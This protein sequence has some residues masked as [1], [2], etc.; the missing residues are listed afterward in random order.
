MKVEI[1][2]PNDIELQ[3]YIQFFYILTHSKETKTRYFIFPNT[4]SVVSFSLNVISKRKNNFIE[5][6]QSPNDNFNSELDISFTTPLLVQY[7]G[8]IKEITIVFKTLGLNVF[9]DKTLNTY[10]KEDYGFYPFLDYSDKMQAILK[11]NSKEEAFEE[12]EKYLLSKI[13]SKSY[14]KIQ[15]IIDDVIENSDVPLSLIAK[16]HNIT[17]KT[18]ITYFNKHI[19]KTP[20]DFK[21][22][23]RFR[24]SLDNKETKTLTELSY[25]SNYFDQ[26]HMIKDFR[27]LT[28]YTPKDFFKKLSVIERGNINWI[29][30]DRLN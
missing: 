16:K 3:K 1:I 26:A 8:D 12:L 25:L 4:T 6:S 10:C 9:L 14:L 21:K 2:K 7:K 17:H 13:K 23:I 29:F 11:M 24:R 5:I 30:T 22:I 20:S 27:K 15:K 18:L 19:C 28:K